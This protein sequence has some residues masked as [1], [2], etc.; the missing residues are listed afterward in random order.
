MHATIVRV[1]TGDQDIATAA[2]VGEEMLRWLSD[3]DGFLGLMMLSRHGTTLTV[4]YWESAEVAAGHSAVREEFRRRI[5][6]VA[7]VQLE[8]VEEL[9]V[10]FAHVGPLMVGT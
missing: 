9:E 6:D 10:M 3:L 5:S 4:T 8:S 7:G 2:I 1:G